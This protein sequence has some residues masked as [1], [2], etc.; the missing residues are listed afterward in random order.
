MFDN[1]QVNG[2][3]FY[4]VCEVCYVKLT[5]ANRSERILNCCRSCVDSLES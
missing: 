5:V 3:P 2:S 4:G 1:K